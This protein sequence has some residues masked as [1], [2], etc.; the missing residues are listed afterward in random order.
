M[1]TYSEKSPYYKTPQSN[2]YLDV[3][4]DRGFNPDTTDV[5]YQVESKYKN[6]PDL[7][8]YDLYGSVDYWWI[9]VIVNNNIHDSIFD[10]TPGKIIR[11]PL[12]ARVSSFFS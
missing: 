2:W 1:V 4:E 8:S 5:N 3:Y 6:R 11:V 12:P 9:F 7:L 10:L